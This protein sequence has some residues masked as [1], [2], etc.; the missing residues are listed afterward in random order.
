MEITQIIAN[1]SDVQLMLSVC[2]IGGG[3]LLGT[4]LGCFIADILF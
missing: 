4:M 3:F 1:A 2:I